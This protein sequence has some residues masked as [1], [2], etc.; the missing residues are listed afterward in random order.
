M[1]RILV[2]GLV[3]VLLVSMMSFA[4]ATPTRKP[5][6]SKD[7]PTVANG[8]GH[9]WATDTKTNQNFDKDWTKDNPG[10]RNHLLEDNGGGI[11]D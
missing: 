4:L 11:V 5:G 2:V 7:D 3:L 10:Y 6:E 1:K 8:Q 9:D